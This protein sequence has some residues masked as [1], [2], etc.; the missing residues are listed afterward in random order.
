MR[1]LDAH[2]WVEA[3][4]PGYGWVTFDP[5]PSAAPPRS[6]SGDRAARRC[7]ATRRDLGGGGAL[8]PRA[9]TARRPSGPPWALYIGG[10]VLAVLLL[11]GGSFAFLHRG[12]YARRRCSSSSA[13]CGARGATPSPGA[14]LQALEAR[15]PARPTPRA[16]CA[17]CA[18]SATAAAATRRRA[19]SAA[20]CAASWGAAAGCAGGCARGGR[21]RRG[22]LTTGLVQL[23]RRMADVYDLFQRGTALLEAGDF[24]PRPSRW[25]RP[26]TSS[27]TRPRSARRSAARTS[28]RP[29]RGRAAE[30]EAVVERAP[31]NDYALFCLGRSLLELGRPKEARKAARAGRRTA[32][33]P[34]RLPHL[35]GPRTRRRIGA[36]GAI[37]TREAFV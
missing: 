30:F 10:G 20:A 25:R 14:T 6:Q 9:G 7:P 19:P 16:T 12:R 2:S 31:T 34:P 35:Q 1:D 37:N 32:S 27:P 17:R 8:D 23:D 28:A 18:S 26:A 22:A 4:F 15:S 11:A 13:R 33:R 29:V 3:W 5:T 21:C 24:T 36:S